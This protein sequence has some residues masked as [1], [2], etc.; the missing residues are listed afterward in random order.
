MPPDSRI[1]A[2][3]TLRGIPLEEPL[4][5]IRSRA[6][7]RSAA[8]LGSG[9]WRWLNLAESPTE[10]PHI[11]P[12]IVDNLIEWLTTPEDDRS[13]RVEPVHSAFD[14]SEPIDFS[15]QIYDE[16]LNPITDAVVTLEIRAPDD[17]IYPYTM[18]NSGSDDLPNGSMRYQREPILIRYGQLE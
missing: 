8:I 5:V 6:G 1:L 11:W 3:T 15:G 10:I 14:G 2:Q 7:Q 18:T 16:S 12:E 17:S 4:F 9:T 13:V